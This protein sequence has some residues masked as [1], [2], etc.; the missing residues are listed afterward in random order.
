M[1]YYRIPMQIIVAR[2]YESLSQKAADFVVSA[3]LLKPS[4]VLALPTGSTPLGMYKFLVELYNRKKVDFSQ[5]KV[6]DLDEYCGL[7]PEH[8][9][10]YAF[11][12]RHN[13]LSQVNLKKENI[14]LQDGLLDVSQASQYSKQFEETIEEVGG[15]DLA[16]L[17]IGRNGHIGFNE[18]G[19]KVDSLT[20]VIDLD[21]KTIQDNS[22]FF[23]NISEVP[24]KA[25]T[26]GIGTILNSQKI[27]LL[28]A[29]KNKAEVINSSMEGPVTVRVPASILQRHPAVT[30]ILDQD[31]A[32]QLKR[33]E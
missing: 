33:K 23:E 13:F 6:F 4:L 21:D 5:V 32:S 25:V 15:I 3:I 24:R 9:Q 7:T 22:R 2:N 19:S 20:R 31:A 10:S 11:Y 1:L 16:I 14:H 30:I 8:S 27:L 12:L 17:G 26:M 18:P 29:G 28:A